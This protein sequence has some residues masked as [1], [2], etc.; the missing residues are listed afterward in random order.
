MG[1][2]DLIVATAGQFGTRGP[3]CSEQLHEIA[4]DA[5]LAVVKEGIG[6]YTC[7]SLS[8]TAARDAIREAERSGPHGFRYCGMTGSP[9]RCRP[10]NWNSR[11]DICRHIC[12]G[13][14]TT[15][16]FHGPELAD[17]LTA[18]LWV[19]VGRPQSGNPG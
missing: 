13:Q 19:K 4:P 10:T 14:F 11:A 18:P 6:R 7:I 2:I 8:A 12:S 1:E 15:R 16:G 17:T 5:G 3:G 9:I